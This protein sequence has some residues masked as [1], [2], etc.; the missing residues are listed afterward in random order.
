MKKSTFAS[1]LVGI[2]IQQFIDHYGVAQ[3]VQAACARGHLSKKES[4]QLDTW[5]LEFLPRYLRETMGASDLM[6][7]DLVAQ[8]PPA[9]FIMRVL[10]CVDFY[11]D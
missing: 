4:A 6:L 5:A 10:A 3:F 2:V 7:L 8:G 11:E 9:G 1:L